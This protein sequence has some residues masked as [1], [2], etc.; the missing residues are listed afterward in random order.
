MNYESIIMTAVR[1]HGK[2]LLVDPPSRPSPS[3]D[4]CVRAHA[5]HAK[6]ETTTDDRVGRYEKL[7]VLAELWLGHMVIWGGLTR[8]ARQKMKHNAAH[9]TT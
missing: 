8:Q 6:T 9:C 3:C 1:F 7:L 2:E 5:A 4:S